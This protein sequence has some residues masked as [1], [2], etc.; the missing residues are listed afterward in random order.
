MH[1][2]M[3]KPPVCATNTHAYPEKAHV[4]SPRSSHHLTRQFSNSRI[5]QGREGVSNIDYRNNTIIM[6]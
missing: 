1:T 6:F 4:I 3:T 2:Y 5:I